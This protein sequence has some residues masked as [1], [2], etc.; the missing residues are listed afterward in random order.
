MRENRLIHLSNPEAGA[1]VEKGLT[2]SADGKFPDF[3]AI[4][5]KVEKVAN[6]GEKLK[7]AANGNPPQATMDKEAE[8][9]AKEHGLEEGKKGQETILA[10]KG[11][12]AENA[13]NPEQN[14][15]VAVNKDPKEQGTIN[16]ASKEKST[17]NLE[18]VNIAKKGE[19]PAF[20][21]VE[22]QDEDVA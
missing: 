14:N 4:N 12:P 2:E 18:Q 7:I 22:K 6:Q 1:D 20:M 15:I 17:E 9:F 8:K 11:K 5:D 10:S 21:N 16:V 13:E 19:I 3:M